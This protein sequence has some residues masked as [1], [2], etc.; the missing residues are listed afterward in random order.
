MKVIHA[1][2]SVL[3]F[4]SLVLAAAF[5]VWRVFP[6]V[7]YTLV[8]MLFVFIAPG[9][10]R[11]QQYSQQIWLWLDQGWQTI[12]APVLNVILRPHGHA[13]F[14]SCDETASSVVGKNRDKNLAF[15]WIDKVLSFFDPAG[16]SHGLASIEDDENIHWHRKEK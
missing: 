15:L 10:T 5:G 6:Y 1:L 14:G 12:L 4:F 13:M 9:H 8:G 2:F 11:P 3:V 7:F 16:G